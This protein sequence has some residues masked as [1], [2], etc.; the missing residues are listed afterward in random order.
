MFGLESQKKKKPGEEF[1]FD[2]EK[3]LKE[4]NKNKELKKKVEQRI[5][6]IK[7]ILRSGDSQDEF[8]RFGLLLHGYT[9]LLKVLARFNPK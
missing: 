8:D 6:K 9:S 1:I 4:Q 3:D 5:Q 2:L 7:E